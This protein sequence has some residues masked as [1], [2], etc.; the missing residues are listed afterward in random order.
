[1]KKKY[2]LL[3]NAFSNSD[4]SEGVK[5]LRS[6]YLTMSKKQKNLKNF[7]VKI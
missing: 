3:F 2:P 6:K 7:F 5:V 4:I 1:M